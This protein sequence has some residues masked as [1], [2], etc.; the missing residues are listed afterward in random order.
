MGF[1]RLKKAETQAYNVKHFN[2]SILALVATGLQCPNQSHETDNM[3]N[4]VAFK[5]IN[6]HLSLFNKESRP[7]MTVSTTVII[8]LHSIVVV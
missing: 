5:N 7:L 3:N 6:D 2:E 8:V 4:E 1:M